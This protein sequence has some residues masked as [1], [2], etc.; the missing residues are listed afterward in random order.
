[1]GC[2]RPGPQPGHPISARLQCQ[3]CPALVQG[4]V[5]R[6]VEVGAPTALPLQAP[7][8]GGHRAR[9]V[10]SVK[11]FWPLFAAPTL[12]QPGFS[13]NLWC[14]WMEVKM[15]L[16]KPELLPTWFLSLPSSSRH[17][18]VPSHPMGS[19]QALALL[20]LGMYIWG[21]GV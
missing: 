20:G 10:H 4:A 19:L 18:A 2:T 3:D 21:Y 11:S 15:Y 8:A 6:L 9:V 5:A 17:R 1:M 12:S 7:L 13:H 16:L 14:Q